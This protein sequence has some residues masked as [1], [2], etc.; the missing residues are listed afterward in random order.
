VASGREA[1]DN[2]ALTETVRGR[3]ALPRFARATGHLLFKITL[4][5][6]TA[7]M[8]VPMTPTPMPPMATPIPF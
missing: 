4:A 8:S 3:V 7:V 6:A 1:G 2:F 5:T